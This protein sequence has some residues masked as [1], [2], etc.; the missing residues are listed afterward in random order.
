MTC[1][2]RTTPTR[3]RW[4][5]PDRGRAVRQG[6]AER[7]VV[8]VAGAKMA[9]SVGNLV[10]VKDL[11]AGLPGGGG[12][13]ADPGPPV[14]PRTGTTTR[15]P[16]RGRRPA[17][18]AA[19]AAGARAGRPAGHDDAAVAAVRAALADDLDVPAAL[20][21]AETEGGPRRPFPRF[22]PR[23]LVALSPCPLPAAPGVPGPQAG[24]A[25]GGGS[26]ARTSPPSSRH[27][28][29]WPVFRTSGVGKPWQVQPLTRTGA[30]PP[31]PRIPAHAHHGRVRVLHPQRGRA[32]TPIPWSTVTMTGTFAPVRVVPQ[33]RA[34]PVVLA[35]PLR[36]AAR[37]HAQP[38]AGRYRG[39]PGAA[40]PGDGPACARKGGLLAAEARR[41]RA[42]CG[43]AAATHCWVTPHPGIWVGQHPWTRFCTRRVPASCRHSRSARFS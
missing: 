4:R 34:A 30:P 38:Q 7:R 43:R 22:P 5:R 31:V 39:Q 25:F 13:A 26:T 17:G 14:E 37:E 10:L 35:E 23:P 40:K 21:I 8:R 3:R 20:R 2:S 36:P 32:G 29:V 6:R 1:A 15:R 18:A 16:G 42:A 12:P 19:A 11:L 28:D 33:V 9:K 27:T 24:P 41:R